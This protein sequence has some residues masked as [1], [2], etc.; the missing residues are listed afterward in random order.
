MTKRLYA[1]ATAWLLAAGVALAA[2]PESKRLGHAKDYI[3]D[4]QWAR[5]IVEL[6]AVADDPKG[7]SRDEALFWLAHS[8]HQTADDAAA[9]QTIARLERDYPRSPWG[10]IAGSRRVEIA[11]RMRR[12]DL[13]WRLATPPPPPAPRAPQALPPATTPAM[14][15]V[16]AT[17]IQPARVPTPRPAAGTPRPPAVPGTSPP[18]S[19]PSAPPRPGTPTATLA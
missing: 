6:K 1:A 12:D 11:Q 14:A 15:G 8:E 10:K 4:E 18:A 2:A 3:A 16:P 9:L 19:T 5:A 13:L 17:P 7:S